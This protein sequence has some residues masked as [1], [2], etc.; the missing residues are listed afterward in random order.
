MTIFNGGPANGKTMM[1]KRAPLYLRVTQAGVKFD[2]LDQLEDTPR[3]AEKVFAYYR[4]KD[5]GSVHIHARRGAGGFYTLATYA[6]L[7]PQP[8]DAQMRTNAAWREWCV[9]KQKGG[10]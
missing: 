8:T 10:V 5:A 9:A 1:L 7:D 6:L 3:P 2:A 4:V